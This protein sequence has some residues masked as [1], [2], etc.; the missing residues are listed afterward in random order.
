MGQLLKGL[1]RLETSGGDGNLDPEA[2]LKRLAKARG[3]LVPKSFPDLQNLPP[4]LSLLILS[5]L[6]ATDLCLAS[7]VWE[8][9]ANDQLLWHG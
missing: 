7:C 4:E 5:H 1:A 8:N 9:L 2:V 3:E 6:N